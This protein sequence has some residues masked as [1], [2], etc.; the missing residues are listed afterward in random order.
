MSNW[1]WKYNCI[2]NL[3]ASIIIQVH[4]LPKEIS[5]VLFDL[6]GVVINIEWQRSVYAFAKLTNSSFDFLNDLMRKEELVQKIET[7]ALTPEQFRQWF[8][9]YFNSEYSDEDIDL[10]WNAMLLDIPQKR[11]ELISNLSKVK[12]VMCLSNTNNIHITALNK[13]LSDSSKY[14]T[15]E[16]L[17][18]KTYYSHLLK[19]RKPDPECWTVIL[20]ENNLKAEQVLYFD[21]N[22]NNHEVAQQLGFQS[23]LIQGD[24]TIESYFNE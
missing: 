4:Q 15:L 23:V 6:G 18:D 19:K 21:D 11:I 9:H 7:G 16:D 5:C 24:L 14:K 12:S 13:I 10:A 8:Q 20:E 2:I 22:E 3:C 17:M 1:L